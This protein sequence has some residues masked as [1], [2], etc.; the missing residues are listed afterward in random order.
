M[1]SSPE[2]E[3]EVPAE[4]VSPAESCPCPDNPELTSSQSISISEEEYQRL[5]NEAAEFKDKYLRLLAEMENTRKRLV[6]ERQEI[7]LLS[8]E[9]I[10]LDFLHPLDNLE[11]ALKFAD[12]ATGEV[13]NW[14]LGF[15]MILDQFKD[16]LAQHGVKAMSVAGQEFDPHHHEAIEMVETND[17]PSGTIIEE[18]TK[19]YQI[20]TKTIRPARVKV[21]STPSLAEDT[22]IDDLTDDQ[23]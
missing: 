6:R 3:K 2:E 19:G 22:L 1:T 11:N 9:R 18:C 12:Q 15:Q 8:N 23:N 4:C 13:K 16:A 20:G 14:A 17:Y 21:A 5:K 7:S 10:I